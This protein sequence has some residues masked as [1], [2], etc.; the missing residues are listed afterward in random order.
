MKMSWPLWYSNA[1]K[2]ARSYNITIDRV[3]AKISYDE[4][5]S[6]LLAIEKQAK[7]EKR[8]KRNILTR[9]SIME[10]IIDP[11]NAFSNVPKNELIHLLGELP[12][13][14]A[15]YKGEVS[16]KEHLEKAYQYPLSHIDNVTINSLTYIWE[17]PG[18]ENLAPLAVCILDNNAMLCI[19][20]YG[21][22]AI[23]E[24]TDIDREKPFCCRMD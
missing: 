5:L 7:A 23:F 24:C 17:Y 14:A 11:L 16:F 2:V 19:Y 3:K 8:D 22:V 9:E 12:H 6:P 10:M 4:G 1:V 20:Y 18:D 15:N 21:L 13:M